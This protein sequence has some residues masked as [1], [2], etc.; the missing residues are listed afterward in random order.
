MRKQSTLAV[1]LIPQD[2]WDSYLHKLDDLTD[3][4]DLTVEKYNFN[5]MRGMSTHK[6]LLEISRIQKI[7]DNCA[8]TVELNNMTYSYVSKW[9]P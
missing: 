8:A 4:L 3:L 6:E 1:P 5:K 2:M 9:R 7:V